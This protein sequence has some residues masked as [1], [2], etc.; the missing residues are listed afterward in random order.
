MVRRVRSAAFMGDAHVFPGGA[1][2]EGDRGPAAAAAVRWHG[3]PEELPWRAAALRELAEEAGVFLTDPPGARAGGR[4]EA[5]YQALAA[6]GAAFAADHL[7]YFSNWVTPRGAP[8][9]FDARFYA[10]EVPPG[11]AAGAD[12]TEVT[13]ACWVRPAE[14]LR[15]AAAGEWRVEFP[16]R[17][18]LEAL[19]ACPDAAAVIAAAPGPGLVPRV[20]PRLAFEADGSWKVLLPGEAGYEEAPA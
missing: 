6:A 7:A 4:G 15:R 12:R 17:K 1:L 19:A 18:H 8:R 2:D 10:V 3:D 16:T 9:R 5:L 13:E 14:A 11:T 20:E